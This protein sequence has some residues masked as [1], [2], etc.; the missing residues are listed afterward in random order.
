MGHR[1]L[2]IHIERLPADVWAYLSDWRHEIEWQEGWLEVSVE[3]LG[4]IQPGTRK[5]K[6]R[7]TALGIQRLTVEA[8]RVDEAGREWEDKVIAGLAT[9]TTSRCRIVA[10][11]A[12]A[13]VEMAMETPSR[14]LA[15]LLT[16]L[17]ERSAATVVGDGLERLKHILESADSE[18]SRDEVAGAR[19]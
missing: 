19:F 7:R 12:G 9:G 11:G 1:E 18:P 5:T 15:R 2:T 13:R 6:A 8:T 17:I 14:G 4:P 16:P 10:E 3:P